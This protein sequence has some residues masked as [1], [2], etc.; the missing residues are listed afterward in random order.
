[1]MNYPDWCEGFFRVASRLQ[2]ASRSLCHASHTDRG[3][4]IFSLVNDALRLRNSQ[5]YDGLFY[6]QRQIAPAITMR[7]QVAL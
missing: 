4:F 1:M 6:E 7:S 3:F 5:S 2:M